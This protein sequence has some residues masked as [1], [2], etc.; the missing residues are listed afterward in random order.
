MSETSERPWLELDVDF[1]DYDAEWSA[2]PRWLRLAPPVGS[3]GSLQTLGQWL[4]GIQGTCPP[5]DFARIRAVI[6]AGDHGIA[7]AGVSAPPRQST[8]ERV[9]DVRAGASAANVLADLVGAGLRIEDISVDSEDTGEYKI[10]RS[11]GRIDT[12]D[13]MTEAETAQAIQAGIAIANA[14]VDAGADLLI[15]G[16]LGRGSTTAAATL[17]AVITE[18]EPV[19]VIGR[20]SGI[21]DDAWMRKAAAVRDARRRAWVHRED[22]VALLTTVGGAD[23]AALAGYL[24]AAASRRTPVLLDGV[25]VAAAAMVATQLHPRALRWWQAAQLSSNSTLPI[26]SAAGSLDSCSTGYSLKRSISGASVASLTATLCASSP[27]EVQPSR[28]LKL[29]KPGNSAR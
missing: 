14:E 2:P 11:S 12:M 5:H 8:A 1:P 17:I 20:G 23:I 18:T 7:E 15:A 16:D 4:C 19:R 26:C 10:R 6:F 22:P 13:A 28:P 24:L 9:A 25:V 27:C 29:P 21:D 3:F